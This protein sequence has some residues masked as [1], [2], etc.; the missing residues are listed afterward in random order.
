MGLLLQPRTTFAQAIME[1]YKDGAFLRH[2]SAD[3]TMKWP[4]LFTPD[5][6]V[7]HYTSQRGLIGILTTKKIWATSIRYLNDS[8]EFAYTLDLM[9]AYLDSRLRSTK[10]PHERKVLDQLKNHL[11]AITKIN[12]CVACF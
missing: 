12:V 4:E 8:M 1:D 10:L 11:E 7:Y 2:G 9:K 6:I 5:R 3:A